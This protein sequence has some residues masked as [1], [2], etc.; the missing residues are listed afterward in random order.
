MRFLIAL[1]LALTIFPA[2]AQDAPQETPEEERSFFLSF[3][4]NRLSTPNRQIRING[5]QGVLS[6]EA[7]IGEITVADRQ[8][9]WLRIT[10]ATIDWSRSTLLL[11]QRLE[12]SR[13][14]ADSI[15]VLR[16]PLPDENALPSPEA[17]A[18]AIP[19]LPIA[20][21]L[22]RLEVPSVS[23]G[24]DIFG[25]QSNL[26]IEGRLRLEGGSLDT[27]LDI[28]R[29]DGPG[30]QLSLQAVYDKPA[31]RFDLDFA[32]SEPQ[33]GVVANL[34]NIE[35]RPPLA[36]T[37]AGSG[38]INDLDLS[39][40]LAAAGEP[41]LSGTAS[42]RQQ[43]EGLGFTVDLGGPIARLI[44][45]R[46][47]SFFGAETSL[48]AAGVAKNGGGLRLDR[49]DL[50]SA[51]LT[52]EANAETAGD[53]FL[54]S[55]SLDANIA[56]AA[57]NQVLLPVSGGET[58]VRTARLAARFGAAGGEDWN[59]SF[60]VQNLQ[61]GTF[62]AGSAT[63]T[64]NG[65]ASNLSTPNERHI[66]Y[67]ARGAVTGITAERAD[68]AEALGREIR[69][70]AGGEWQAGEPLAIDNAELLGN[71]LAAT[72]S[73][74]MLEFA[75]RGDIGLRA[76]SIA[77]FSAL[78]SR[79][80]SGG[81]DL[82]ANGEVRPISGAFDLRLDGT[83]DE[84]RLG[85]EALDPLLTGQTRLTGRVARTTEGF[86]AEG[87]RIASEQ[88]QLTADGTFSSQAADFRF[89][90]T[91][92]DL[93]VI[94]DRAQGRLT[95]TGRALGGNGDFSL[96]FAAQVPTGRLL[97]KA[98]ENAR[99]SFDGRLRAEALTG[100]IVG[101]AA[102][103]GTPANL[104]ADLSVASGER[105]LTDIEFSTRGAQLSGD[106]AQNR[107]G[108]FTGALT[109]GATDI[110]TAAALF[111][112]EAQGAVNA[113]LSFQP[114]ENGQ[115]A[116]VNASATR[117]S[118]PQ[119]SLESGEAQATIDDLFGVPAVEGNLQAG[120]LKLA[121]I[122][123][124]TLT[125]NA[126]TSGDATNFSG[127]AALAN[128]TDI[129][130]RGTLAPQA[131]GYLLT[132]DQAELTQAAVSARLLQAAR[133]SVRGDTVSFD[134]MRL[135]VAGGEVI[136]QG[137]V[138]QTLNVALGLT[139]VPLSIANT[140]RPDLALG[141]TIDGEAAISGTREFP[142]ANF[143]LTGR[144][145][146][147][148][149][150]RQAGI[151]SLAVEANGATQG[152]TLNLNARMTSPNGLNATVTG[153]VP[154]S[155]GQMAVDINLRSF[156]LSLLNTRIP[157]QDLGGSLTGSA[158]VTG[159]LQNPAAT[160]NAE[161][162]GLTARTLSS[163]G[164]APLNV[165]ALGSFAGNSVDL[166]T[167]S[168]S[169]P[170]GLS[171]SASGRIPLMGGGLAL[172][173]RGSAPLSLANRLL[174]DRGT[175]LAGTALADLQIGGSLAVPAI[176]GTLST[177]GASVVDPGSN[178]RLTGISVE[179]ALSGETVT[180]RSGSAAVAEGGTVSLSGT[181]STNASAG[182]PADLAMRL[183]EARYADGELVTATVS[184]QLRLTGPITRDPLLSGNIEISRAEIL[185]PDSF[186][187]SAASLN[188][189]HINPSPAVEETLERA[190]A[191]DGTPMPSAR[192]SVMRLDVNINAPARIFVRGRGL[193]A[194]L[195][196]SVQITGPVTSVQPVGGF[197]LIR[198]RLS[199]LAQRIT[200]DEA[201]VSLVGDLDPFLDFVA[202]S[203][204]SDITVFITVRGRVSDP[205]VVFSSQP[206]L[207]QDEVLARLLFN[208][209]VDQ[210]SP[211][212]LAQL[213]AAA[214]ELAG[215][216]DTSLL[217]SLRS[218]TGLDELDIVTT[219]EGNAAVRAGR[220]I[221]ENVYLGVEA[222]AGGTTRGTINLDLTDNLRVRG[223]VGS[224]G[225]SD[226][227]IFY[228]RDY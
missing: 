37:L 20:I 67:D 149:A 23:F 194:E 77:P 90:T 136:A 110:S 143:N 7:T 134:P 145:I 104:R 69:F 165:S 216:S 198:G 24:Q 43:Q 64:L 157:G 154:F 148:A 1:L 80:L 169:G 206:E 41:A 101:Q 39:M 174:A 84:L 139:R 93:A 202:R 21:N 142:Q 135:D 218:A 16:P 6:S 124:A 188:V 96:T 105:R 160:F 9:I 30:G 4:E 187:G 109:L 121:G 113:Q 79:E 189:R 49:L 120:G 95:A 99:I 19:E 26:S 195:G 52:L 83:A 123:V 34:L 28:T 70:S 200:F 190:R 138:G 150:L 208:R 140:I 193:D 13:L 156:P 48:E 5:I 14:T 173:L 111:L 31:E 63:I 2:L 224:N 35:G 147:A 166:R 128:G 29:L 103:E 221:Q 65:T 126:Q 117:L 82:T 228:E 45:T 118:L 207:P 155:Q 162:T 71:G 58:S 100:Q 171:I 112:V 97:D 196:G 18:F 108:L 12:I 158:R 15:E 87:F 54:T 152:E 151:N 78:A 210:L 22:G 76:S 180:I 102:L 57:G 10:N 226:L 204:G 153:A 213:A 164:A 217:G 131:G 17:R 36:L 220:Y 203:E 98:L 51:A 133:I 223:G 56:D 225:D 214:A 179:A 167:L 141:G 129:S 144:N 161:A 215:G 182:F 68:I 132:L 201:T 114:R 32:L 199:I 185:V 62:A 88:M 146:T 127:Q 183:N 27:A 175:Q 8:G 11:R 72:L 119:L 94:T 3:V 53:G 125:A 177:S 59:A 205:E 73:G 44:P 40:T 122:Q 178:L 176:S 92:E 107:E 85:I 38:P 170:A 184:G 227:G 222:G 66:T 172:N 211:L 130:A 55:L 168:A 74:T 81:V 163:V 192:P 191:D 61:T 197:R 75:F 46:F 116:S 25:L 186:G 209:G 106:I 181:V 219:D 42:F 86:S 50:S 115:H 89:D 33:N 212:Q 47:R 137:E 91:L 60:D 159:T